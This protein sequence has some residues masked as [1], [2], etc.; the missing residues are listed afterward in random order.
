MA[1]EERAGRGGGAGRCAGAVVAMVGLL[2]GALAVGS[3]SAA[4]VAEPI[5][6]GIRADPRPVPSP[7]VVPRPQPIP[8]PKVAPAPRFG[9]GPAVV[10]PGVTG[11]TCRSSC[12]SRCQMISCSGLNVSQCASVRQQCRVS[13]TSRC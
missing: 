1:R 12:A 5:V 11:P 13:C 7:R 3:A 10:R 2:A 6:P 4:D 8:V 9:P